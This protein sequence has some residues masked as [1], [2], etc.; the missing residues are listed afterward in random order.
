VGAGIESWLGF[1]AT[2]RI[3]IVLF[4]ELRCGGGDLM[5]GLSMMTMVCE[6]EEGKKRDDDT[7][8]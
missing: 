1:M 4:A 3:M 7:G 6:R 8:K 5:V 2:S